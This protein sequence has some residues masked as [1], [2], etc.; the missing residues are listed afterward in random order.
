MI[1]RK[2]NLFAGICVALFSIYVSPCAYSEAMNVTD[3]EQSIND[4]S[5]AGYGE[6]GKKSWDLCGRSADIFK[7][8][9]KLQDVVGNLYGKEED[10]KLTAERGDFNKSSGTVHL[11]DN[12]VITTSAG[13]RLTA[14]S[15]DWD[16]KNQL[17]TTDTKV[18]IQKD[19][20]TVEA[21]GA[22]GEP[23][24]KKVALEKD[25]RLDINASQNEESGDPGAKGKITI[26]CDGPLEID[27]ARNTAVF[28][29]N[30]KVERSDS[31]IYSDKMVAYFKTDNPEGSK[32]T[33]E[34]MGANF[35][36]IVATG[37]VRVVRG[38]NVSYSEEAI[39]TAEDRKIVLKG[40]PR[41][42]ISTAEEF[43]DAPS[44]N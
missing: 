37:N 21:T 5:L 22:R 15:L 1:F 2:A 23:G 10:V 8:L 40:N 4:F 29:N 43:K 24:L 16:R 26:T 30:V 11:E 31:V 6:K 12:V 35:E 20:M 44:G 18:N 25:V 32:G 36:K 38:E 14:D 7:D 39:Y 19:N 13:A 17:V 28:N 9:V 41:L 27:Y 3:A 42:V 34:S 33:Q